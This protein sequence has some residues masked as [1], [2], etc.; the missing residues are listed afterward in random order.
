MVFD[1]FDYETHYKK[2]MKMLHDK[3]IVL[4]CGENVFANITYNIFD[5]AKSIDYIK[6]KSM[7]AFDDFD[8]LL[9]KCKSIPK[10]RVIAFILGPTSKA[11]V[12]EL[13]KRGYIAWDIGH[14][15]KDY[16][17]YKKNVPRNSDRVSEF[18]APE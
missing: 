9:D 11:L 18:F 3:D 5:Y 1:E 10:E 15:A 8:E 16:D 6:C 13:S 12:Y 14:L 17:Y 4:F 2:I 7:D